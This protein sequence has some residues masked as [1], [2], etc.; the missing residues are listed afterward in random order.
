MRTNPRLVDSQPCQRTSL[1]DKGKPDASRGRK[2]TGPTRSAELPKRKKHIMRRS[3]TLLGSL[4]VAAAMIGATAL[5]ASAAAGDTST[6]FSLSGGSLSS[7]VQS[8]A[9]LTGASTAVGST[10]ITGPLGAVTVTDDRGG[11]AV[12][13]VSAVSAVFTGAL[14]TSP[15]SSTAVSYT[16]G[17]VST[18]GTITV[19]SG[20]A[21]TLDPTTPAAVVSPSALS[22]NNT[23]SW[24]PTLDVT[25]PAGA[26]ADTYTGI[27]TTSVA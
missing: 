12:W 23:A 15:S 1:V 5:P 21:T 4:A 2:A 11:T 13:T 25:M 7:S 14:I 20:A 6:T 19:I 22:G 9:T 26:K 16:G 18:T 10:V 27:V 24:T 3:T 17:A 8:T